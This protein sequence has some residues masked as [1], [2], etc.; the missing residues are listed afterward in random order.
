MK[1]SA[2]FDEGYLK[3]AR[4]KIKINHPCQKSAFLHCVVKTKESIVSQAVS[5]FISSWKLQQINLFALK[6][7]LMFLPLAGYWISASNKIY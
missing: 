3:F 4:Y 1:D 7:W 5:M 2:D 6:T